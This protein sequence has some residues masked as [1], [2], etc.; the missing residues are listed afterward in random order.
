LDFKEF[1]IKKVQ[2][3]PKEYDGKII[4]KLLAVKDGGPSL[5]CINGMD[6]KFDG[7]PWCESNNIGM[8]NLLVGV[9]CHKVLYFENLLC[10]NETW[11]YSIKYGVLNK[12]YWKG[13]ATKPFLP[14]FI[15]PDEM[16]TCIFCNSLV[17]YESTC[18]MHMLNVIGHLL[19]PRYSHFVVHVG[20]HNHP[21][22]K[23]EN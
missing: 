13:H 20:L 5:S 11:P 18:G 9:K 16:Y 12:K 19:S 2:V 3:L 22:A 7:H 6:F 15:V 8:N 21:S 14:N 17:L 23:G 4:F 10:A 1:E